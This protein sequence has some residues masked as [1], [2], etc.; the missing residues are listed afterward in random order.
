MMRVG[1]SVTLDQS[2]GVENYGKLHGFDGLALTSN[3][4]AKFVKEGR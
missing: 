1:D 3:L 4:S 2:D